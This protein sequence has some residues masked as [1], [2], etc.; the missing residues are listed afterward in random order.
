MLLPFHMRAAR[1]AM[2]ERQQKAAGFRVLRGRM[3]WFRVLGFGFW[4]FHGG[5]CIGFAR[6]VCRACGFTG[7]IGCVG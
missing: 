1:Y 5:L 6:R 2:R 3:G 4:A 7:L